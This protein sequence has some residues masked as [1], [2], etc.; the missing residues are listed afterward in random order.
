VKGRATG[1][2]VPDEGIVQAKPVVRPD[3]TTET[4]NIYQRDGNLGLAE[5][6]E[7][8]TPHFVPLEVHQRDANL[9]LR[10]LKE[11]GTSHFAPL[12]VARLNRNPNRSGGF[13]MYVGLKLPAEYALRTGKRSITVPLYQTEEDKRRGYL[14]TAHVRAIASES[15]DFWIYY[16][17]RGYSEALNRRIEDTLYRSH[18]ARSVGWQRQQVDMLGLAALIN[19]LTRERIRVAASAEAA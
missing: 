18:R 1:R 16:K 13:R 12:K 2:R 15:H 10:T 3:G 5:L 19:A 6:K 7:D 4:I 11:D 8:G 17:M 9:G 14:R